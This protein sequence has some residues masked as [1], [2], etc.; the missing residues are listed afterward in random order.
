MWWLK[1]RSPHPPQAPSNEECSRAWPMWGSAPPQGPCWVAKSWSR[2]GAALTFLFLIFHS[3]SYFTGLSCCLSLL[4]NYQSP[5][6]TT[7]WEYIEGASATYSV[8]LDK[9]KTDKNNFFSFYPP[10][11]AI[12]FMIILY[13]HQHDGDRY[14]HIPMPEVTCVIFMTIL[15]WTVGEMGNFIN[16]V[17]HKMEH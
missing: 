4:N 10:F 16:Q 3:Q 13:G 6:R 2:R 17:V 8:H 7:S 9:T 1:W 11:F 12:V 14:G 5:Q 15:W